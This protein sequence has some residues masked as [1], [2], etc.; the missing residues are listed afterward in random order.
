MAKGAKVAR[1]SE[2]R[3]GP[4]EEW[5]RRARRGLGVGSDRWGTSNGRWAAAD[6]NTTETRRNMKRR[7]TSKK[8]Q[9]GRRSGASSI[10]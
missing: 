3:L 2:V 4:T 7:Y 9:R 6:A 5:P 8:K 1:M 10:H